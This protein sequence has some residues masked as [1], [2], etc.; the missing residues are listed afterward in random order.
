M[1]SVKVLGSGCTKCDKLYS[2]VERAIAQCGVPA[3]LQK[4]SELDDIVGYGVMLT[5][6]L[7]IDE[8][9]K[10]SGRLPSMSKMTTWLTTAASKRG[11]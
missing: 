8:E 3:D 9:V 7:V 4:V 1:V 2:E 10:S 6:A 5:P 11:A